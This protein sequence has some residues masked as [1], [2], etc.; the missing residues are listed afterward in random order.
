MVIISDF[1]INSSKGVYRIPRT[2]SSTGTESKVV[3]VK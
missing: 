1:S 2:N 3:I